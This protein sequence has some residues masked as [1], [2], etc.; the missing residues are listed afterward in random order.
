MASSLKDFS[1]DK[2]RDDFIPNDSYI[3][4]DF[5][6]LEEERLWP[7]VWQLACRLEEIP[8]VGD[9]CTY[10]IVDDSIIVVHAEKDVIKAFH[11]A[12]SH[13]G[14]PL[15][16]GC[17]RA[18]RFHCRFHGWKYS[19]K[20]ECIEIVDSKD[21]NG[22]LKSKDVDLREVNV[23]TWGGAVFINMDPECQPF[24]EFLRPVD[25]FMG[26]FE[27]DKLRYRWYKTVIMPVNW[28][29][30]LEA[31]NEF[32]HV[33][34]AH[35]QLLAFTDDYSTSRGFGRHGNVR[36]AAEG[37]VPF[38]RSPRL[39]PKEVPD[40]RDYILDFVEQYNRDLQA[41]VTPRMHRATQ[42][43]RTEVE[44]TAEPAEVLAKWMQFLGEAA[45][46]D[47]VE[48]PSELTPE[49]I[50]A[51]GFDWH[52]FPNTIFLHSVDGVLWYRARP[53]GQDPNSCIFDVWA[54]ERYAPGKEPPLKREFYANWREGEWPLIYKQ[55]F[56]NLDQLQRGMKSRGFPGQLV[57]PLQER[58]ISNFHR[59]LRR[60]MQDPHDHP[61]PAQE[62]MSSAPE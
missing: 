51:S 54:L 30:V 37:T 57:S 19:L 44:A 56:V 26:K 18:E 38:K 15:T 31:F 33:Q 29:R 47:G 43:L 12:C 20:G 16:Q 9:Y 53:N 60:F 4:P 61:D 14:L 22:C 6:R 8:N 13:R 39:P 36:F 3:D 48:F 59:A 52:V 1:P 42:R 27:F 55:D 45:A 7:K 23:A 2:I 24:E 17:G 49:Y 28:K 46:E 32:Y 35:A 50:E 10:D 62:A 21:W 58:T 40:Y 34:Q 11:N 25:D 41:I 5:A